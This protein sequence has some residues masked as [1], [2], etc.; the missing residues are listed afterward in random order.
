MI[1]KLQNKSNKKEALRHQQKGR[2][3]DYK[4]PRIR[5]QK[6]IRPLRNQPYC[7]KT[8]SGETPSNSEVKEFLSYNSYPAEVSLKSGE[9]P[10]TFYY[11]FPH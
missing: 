9:K 2:K 5:T 8:H 10:V 1:K 7:E 4:K 3:I 11:C 6:S